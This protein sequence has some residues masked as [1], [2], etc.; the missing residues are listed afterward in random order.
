M[1][2][3]Q[4]D[5]TNIDAQHI[6]CAIGNDAENKRNANLKKEW[7]RSQ[8]D[9]GLVFYRLDERGKV[10]IEYMPAE[11]CWKPV[12]APNYLVIHCLWV[13]GQFKGRGHSL[14]LL[15]H[16]I[17]DAKS[18][19]KAG[20]AVVTAS[21]KKP[22][23]TDKTFFAKQGFEVADQAD[24]YFELMA[25]KFDPNSPSP[26]FT[27]TAKTG[28]LPDSKGLQLVYSDQCVFMDK[29]VESIRRIAEGMGIACTKTKLGSHLQAQKMGSPFGTL[30][31]Y[32]DG[33]FLTHELMA[34][35]KMTTF[36]RENC[37]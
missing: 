28:Q 7:M 21:K 15:N 32:Y 12:V 37:L 24:P 1:G 16:C 2:Y 10:F 20:V 29:Y 4:L 11:F 18:Q 6:C 33:A 25:F 9:N 17:I 34:E 3:I 5:A 30:G 22:F 13:S 23:L 14:E 26:A 35:G 36:L 31:I 27:K 8:F 19:S